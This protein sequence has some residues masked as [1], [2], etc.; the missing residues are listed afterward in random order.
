M[1]DARSVFPD[2]ATSFYPAGAIR[3]RTF[4]VSREETADELRRPILVIDARFSALH[5]VRLRSVDD[6]KAGLYLAHVIG[7]R[8]RAEPA[9]R[10]G[11]SVST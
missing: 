11:A 10:K 5:R 3:S 4:T 1:S 8:D 9:T 6:V 2:R 7:S